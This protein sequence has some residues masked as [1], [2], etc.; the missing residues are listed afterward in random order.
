MA[1][2]R[3]YQ[4]ATGVRMTLA[5]TLLRGINTHREDAR[6]L[7]E[8]T[9]VQADHRERRLVTHE[10]RRPNGRGPSCVYMCWAA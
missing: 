3:E 6:K 7:A 9:A 8:L 2:V 10:D 4:Q 5:W 1:A